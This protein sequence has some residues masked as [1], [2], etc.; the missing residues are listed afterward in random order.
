M[1]N[2]SN[3][4]LR[5]YID[6]LNITVSKNDKYS[7]EA[8]EK[9]VADL[10]AEYSDENYSVRESQSEYIEQ[11]TAD[12][13]EY[14]EL[15]KK[16]SEYIEEINKQYEELQE[17]PE[18]E[19]EAIE[20]SSLSEEKVGEIRDEFLGKRISNSEAIQE[21]RK[22]VE[23][24]R[25]QLKTIGERIEQ[26]RREFRFAAI[27]KLTQKECQEIFASKIMQEIIDIVVSAK[28]STD[29]ASHMKNI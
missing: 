15:S 2:I 28:K 25:A 14:E 21:L 3:S 24:T 8:F 18:K 29:I 4:E 19:R 12:I 11:I 13:K 20:N 16:L 5:G 9:E 23:E 17:H 27:L 1:D 10:D 22:K 26:V 6:G 7:Q